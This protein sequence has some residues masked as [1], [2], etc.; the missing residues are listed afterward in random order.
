MDDHYASRML[1]PVYVM[2]DK[3]EYLVFVGLLVVDVDS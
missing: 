1:F 2:L 3:R